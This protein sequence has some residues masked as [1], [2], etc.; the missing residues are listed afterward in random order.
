M[1]C[2]NSTEQY[3]TENESSEEKRTSDT[4]RQGSDESN[5]D[6]PGANWTRGRLSGIPLLV[7]HGSGTRGNGDVTQRVRGPHSRSRGFVEHGSVWG[8]SRVEQM[9][10]VTVCGVLENLVQLVELGLVVVLDEVGDRLANV[11]DLLV[12][13]TKWSERDG[14]DG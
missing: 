2:I 3:H 12:P 5:N 10:F 6:Q 4:A 14:V 11:L 7:L 1:R 13:V 8:T 9:E